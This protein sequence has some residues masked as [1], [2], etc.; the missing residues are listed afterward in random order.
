MPVSKVLIYT[1]DI[2]SPLTLALSSGLKQS[3]QMP[4][5]RNALRFTE[6]EVE[7]CYMCI[8]IMTCARATY[9]ADVHA[10]AGI[11]VIQ[12][13]GSY[14]TPDMYSMAISTWGGIPPVYCPDDR[15]EAQG[16]D[17]LCKV[18]DNHVYYGN[19]PTPFAQIEDPKE[20]LKSFL[21]RVA[22]A[23]WKIEE[24]SAGIPFRFIMDVASGKWKSQLYAPKKEQRVVEHEEPELLPEGDEA[25][26]EPVVE[27]KRLDDMKLTEL[28]QLAQELGLSI[29]GSKEVIRERIIGA[30]YQDEDADH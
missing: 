16:L 1:N 6:G 8:V 26:Q 11:P 14:T 15:C 28:R 9:I 30:G 5:L 22:Y 17:Y 29:W 27:K 24:I 21:A 13:G 19:W 2:R 23:Q 25:P 18:K 20:P 10:Q 12:V 7:P 3:H 4:V